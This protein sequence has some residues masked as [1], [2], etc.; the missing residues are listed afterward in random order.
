MMEKRYIGAVKSLMR[1]P[2]KSMLGEHVNELE[3]TKKGAIGDRAYA[4]REV[5]TGRIVTAKKWA[6]MFE[7]QAAYEAPPVLG[8]LAPVRISLPDGRIIHAEDPDASVVLS[9]VLGRKVKLERAQADEHARAEIDPATV[10]GDVPVEKVIPGLTAASMPDSFGLPKG[11]WF[12]A[13]AIHVLASGTLEHMRRLCGEDAQLDPRRFRPNI[14]VETPSRNEGF[15]EDEWLEGVLEVGET[16]K[17]VAMRS[18]LRCVMTTHPQTDL[19]RDMRI[20]RAA[21]F[22]HQAKV[23]VFASVGEPGKVRIGDPVI[24][25]V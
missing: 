9:S 12:D 6:N 16:L 21:A 7:F 1:Y 20:L 15:V 19:R 3:V 10:F 13:A 14:C 17:I 24:L 18:A 8:A 11:T 23:G 25:M 22:H 5:A 4:L 2:V